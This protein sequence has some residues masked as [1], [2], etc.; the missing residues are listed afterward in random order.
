MLV[1]AVAVTTKTGFQVPAD[2]PTSDIT[3]FVKQAK[4]AGSK[5]LF[6]IGGW[7]GSLYFSSLVDTPAKQTTFAKQI[8]RFMAQYG[9]EGVDL[10]GHSSF[11][12]VQ[13]PCSC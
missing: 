8:Q 2:Q 7:T 3:A 5:P 9:F 4:Q 11:F 6:S 13:L 12:P 1:L 10:G